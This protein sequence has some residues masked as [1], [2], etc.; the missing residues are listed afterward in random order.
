M[1]AQR[2]LRG[3]P[4]LQELFDHGVRVLTVLLLFT[5]WLAS[6]RLLARLSA[7]TAW[8]H[9]LAIR[10]LL[11]LQDLI[12]DE[13]SVVILLLTSRAF[14]TEVEGLLNGCNGL[15]VQLRN[16]LLLLLLLMAIVQDFLRLRGL[17]CSLL[18]NSM[19]ALP[20]A[21]RRVRLLLVLGD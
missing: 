7:T 3:S 17:I 19:A 8:L 4:I 5:T 13:L 2:R 10:L 11:E 9:L 14:V 12:I 6:R 16:L 15:G 18:L 1:K 21:L 20:Q